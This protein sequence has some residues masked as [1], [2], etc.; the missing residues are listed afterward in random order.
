VIN[1]RRRLIPPLS[2]SNLTG[3]SSTFFII[4]SLA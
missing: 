1:C 3:H 4:S 2:G